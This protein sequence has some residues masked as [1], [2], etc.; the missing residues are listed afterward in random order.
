MGIAICQIGHAR[1]GH[2]KIY[3][4]T[5][6]IGYQ[7]GEPFWAVKSAMTIEPHLAIL[8]VLRNEPLH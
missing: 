5:L 3:V 8:I 6:L 4:L 1:W 7:I 2:N